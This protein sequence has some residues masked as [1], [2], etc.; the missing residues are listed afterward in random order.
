MNF[1]RDLT[2]VCYYGSNLQYSS[3]G[4]DNGLTP[5][6]DGYFTDAFMRHSASVS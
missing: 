1:A 5:A 3:I 2:E 6:Y 4:L